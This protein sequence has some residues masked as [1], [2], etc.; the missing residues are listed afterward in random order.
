M[1]NEG[2]G[3]GEYEVKL[4]SEGGA[5]VDEEP[6]TYWTDVRAGGTAR[7]LLT[8][9]WDPL[10]DIR[11]VGRSY[12]VNLNLYGGGTEDTCTG[13]LNFVGPKAQIISVNA[14]EMGDWL[15]DDEFEACV[16]FANIGRRRANSTSSSI[17]PTAISSMRNP[18]A[19]GKI[20][21]QDIKPR[22]ASVPMAFTNRWATWTGVTPWS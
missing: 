4:Y 22:S 2:G 21:R 10:W 6:D 8:T 16:T 3:A 11:D 1:R 7:F 19:T 18:T 9:N 5:E 20:C 14:R 17:P 15:G 13:D 12:S